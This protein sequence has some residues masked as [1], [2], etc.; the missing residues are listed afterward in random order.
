MPHCYLYCAAYRCGAVV[1]RGVVDRT[2]LLIFNNE[3]HVRM[4]PRIAALRSLT[5]GGGGG[6]YGRRLEFIAPDEF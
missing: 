2:A 1:L 5:R 4:R 6:A 3:L